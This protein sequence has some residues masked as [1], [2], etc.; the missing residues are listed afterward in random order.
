MKHWWKY[1]PFLA[2]ATSCF[3]EDDPVP[4][5]QSPAGVTTSVAEMGPEYGVQLFYD[6]ESYTF[7]QSVNRESWDLAFQCGSGYH[8]FLNGSKLM[9]IGHTGSTDWASVNANTAVTWKWDRSEGQA[10]STAIGEWGELQGENVV[11][12]NLVYVVDRGISTQGYDLGKKKMQITGLVNDEYTIR[13]ANL[14]GTGEH[15]LSFTRNDD[16]N[17]VF[18]SLNESGYTV[19]VEPPKTDW[20]LEFTQ[21]TALVEQIGTGIVENYSVNGVLLNPYLVEGAREFTKP[22]TDIVYSDIPLMSFTTQ[23][24]IIGYEWKEYDF[25][26]STYIIYPG[27][28]YLVKSVE[29]NYFKLRFTS[30]T[31][32][33]GVRGYPTFEVA[34]F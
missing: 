9:K 17:C 20:D 23:R 12:A 15:T 22:F 18:V 11:S 33:Q 30:F 28:S 19:M 2:L 5:Y 8:A 10:D 7:I 13:F 3:Q 24:D 32:N 31:N 26:L 1:L 21:Y 29:G 6:L 27:Q 16:Y 14:D 25:D 34:K 4:P